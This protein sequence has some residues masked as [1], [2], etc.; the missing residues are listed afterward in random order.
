MN[1]VNGIKQETSKIQ[2]TRNYLLSFFIKYG[3]GEDFLLFPIGEAPEV[4]EYI[5]N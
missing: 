4:M 3:T 2:E 1:I 5:S